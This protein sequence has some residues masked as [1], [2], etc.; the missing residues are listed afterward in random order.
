MSQSMTGY[1]FAEHN[2]IRVEMRSVNHRFLDITIKMPQILIQYDVEM[3][4]ELKGAFSRGHIDV[5]VTLLDTCTQQVKINEGLLKNLVNTL[6]LIKESYCLAGDIDLATLLHLGQAIV[7]EPAEVEKDALIHAFN[8]ALER[9]LQMR[10]EEGA[11][12]VQDITGR[13]DAIEHI[14]DEISRCTQGYGERKMSSLTKKLEE[15]L[16]PVAVD[17]DR[18]L[19]EVAYLVDKAD[20][21]EEI[22]RLQS[23]LKLFR[24]NLSNNDKIGRK[25]DFIIQEL[26][27]EANTLAS[28]SEEYAVSELAVNLK[29]EIEQMREQIQNLQ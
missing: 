20:F 26:N 28:K 23:H 5:F 6:R 12:L 18:L 10:Q 3:R 7:A 29:N 25:M 1:G 14:V 4:K 9:L 13:V 2:G 17:R 16:G 19:Q 21:S 8:E 11:V 15:L 24:Q 22:V 27:R